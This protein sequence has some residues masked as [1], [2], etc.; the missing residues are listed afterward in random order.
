MQASRQFTAV[1]IQPDGDVGNS[2][3]EVV[4]LIVLP[5]EPLWLWVM[6]IQD[7]KSQSIYLFC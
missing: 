5:S 6:H 3:L 4:P 2:G 7:G 1:V